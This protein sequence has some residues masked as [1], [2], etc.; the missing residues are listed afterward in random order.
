MENMRI[1]KFHNEV[2]PCT[3]CIIQK[4]EAQ[5]VLFSTMNLHLK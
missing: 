4:V 1:W 3:H 2:Y 5:S